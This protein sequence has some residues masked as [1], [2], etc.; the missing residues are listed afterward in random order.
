MCRVV[1]EAITDY[2]PVL[3]L[4]EKMAAAEPK[5][6][7]IL[8]LY[9][10]LLYRAGKYEAAFQQ[11]ELALKNHT[12]PHDLMYATDLLYQAMC[13]QKL[14]WDKEAKQLVLR[15][16]LTIDARQAEETRAIALSNP[17]ELWFTR[18]LLRRGN[19]RV[20]IATLTKPPEAWYN[21]LVLRLLRAE[22]EALAK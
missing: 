2:A 5:N 12:G 21:H 7:S 14:N 9:G 10:H 16:T 13:Q 3:K 6:Y 17:S 19:E 1:P 4:A 22:A 8:R 20:P 15:A 18:L 11:L